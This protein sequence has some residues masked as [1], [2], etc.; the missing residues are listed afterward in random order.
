MSSSILE[1]HEF[2]DNEDLLPS[3]IC[4]RYLLESAPTTTLTTRD[5][6][7][8]VSTTACYMCMD[9]PA[10]TVLI[11]CGHGGLCIACA[12]ALWQRDSG[13]AAAA[14]PPARRCPLCRRPFVGVM[15]IVSQSDGKVA[16]PAHA[17]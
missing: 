17:R 7:T 3:Y 9:N 10:D 1:Q 6:S 12:G 11:E 15:R 2:D 5:S 4:G 8:P 16:R 13:T 14:A